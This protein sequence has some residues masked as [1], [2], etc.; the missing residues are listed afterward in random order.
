MPGDTDTAPAT[1]TYSPEER[2]YFSSGEMTREEARELA[3]IPWEQLKERLKNDYLIPGLRN[4]FSNGD[5]N[6]TAEFTAEEFRQA[7]INQTTLKRKDYPAFGSGTWTDIT[8]W[9][10]AVERINAAGNEVINENYLDFYHAIGDT[11][12][13]PYQQLQT[14]IQESQI[15]KQPKTGADPVHLFNGNFVFATTDL[16]IDGAGMNF[17]F[18]RTYSQLD[19]YNGPLGFNWDHSYNL[20]LRVSADMQMITASTGILR[21]NAYRKHYIYDYWTPSD[22]VDTILLQKGNTFLLRNPDGSHVLYQQHPTQGP[23]IHIVNRIEDRFGNYLQFFYEDGKLNKIAVNHV[24]RLVH[25]FYDTFDR[26]IAIK[27]FTQRLWKYIYDDMGDLLAVTTPGTVKYKKGLTTFY[28][29]SSSSFS[30]PNAQH[31]LISIIDADGHIYLENEYGIEKNL[32]SYN[33]VIRQRLGN[34]DTLFDY[35]DV[36][37]N[38]EYPYQ[39]NEQPTCQTIVTERDGMQARYLFNRYGNMIFKEEYARLNG[40]PKLISSHYRY[41][42]EGNLIGVIS[43]MGFI[44]QYLY[45][46]DYFEKRFPQDNDYRC[47]NDSNLTQQIRQGFNTLLSVVKRK[48]YIN[49]NMSGG[50]WSEDIFPD[51]YYANHEDIIQK[52][53]YENKFFQLITSSDPRFT[54]SANPNIVEPEIYHVHLTKYNYAPGNGFDFFYLRSL[55]L[56]GSTLPDGTIAEPL[57]T[58]FEEYDTK[59]RLIK[60]VASNGLIKI[61]NYYGEEDGLLNGFLKSTEIDPAGIAIKTG[62]ERD[63]LGRVTKIYKPKYY[64]FL[65]DRFFSTSHYD[66]LN[67]VVKSISSAPLSVQTFNKYNR[68]GNLISSKT[69][70]KDRGNMLTGIFEVNSKYD[71][72]FHLISQDTGNKETGQTKRNKNIHDRAGR[73][74]ISI[75]ASGFKTKLLYNERGLQW[76]TITDYG[77]VHAVTKN[78]FDADGR[79]IRTVDPRGNISRFTYDTLG[80]PVDTEDAKGNKSIRHYDKIGNIT[81]E[82]FFEKE[83]DIRY[84]LLSR[85]EYKHDEIGRVIKAGINKFDE[86]LVVNVNYLK[87][88]FITEGPGEL[89]VNYFF[90]N[91]TGK[92]YKTIDQSGKI[93]TSDFDLLGRIIKKTDP[94]GNELTYQYDKE[95]NIIRTDRKEVT[96]NK[97]TNEIINARYFAETAIYDEKNRII[98]KKNSLG[99]KIKY[100]YDSRNNLVQLIDPLDNITQNQYDLFSR[101][102]HNIR[103]LHKYL[104]GE[105]PEEVKTSYTYNHFDLIT[106]QKDAL[107]R[108]TEFIYNSSGRQISSILPDG[109]ADMITYDRLGNITLYKDR[110]GL[111][112]IFKYDELNRNIELAIDT[113]TLTEGVEIYGAMKFKTEYDGMSRIVKIENDH[114]ITEYSFNSLGFNLEE[115]NS[116]KPIAGMS[117][118]SALS[119][120]REFNVSGSQISLTYPSGRRIEYDRDILER[121]IGFRQTQKGNDYPGD[122]LTPENYT[123]AEIEYEGLQRK[124]IRKSNNS[125]TEFNYDFGARLIEIKH[126][127][128]NMFF[129]RLQFIFDA[130]NNMRQQVEFSNEFQ[131]THS[132]SYDSFSRILTTKGDDNAIVEELSVLAPS[133]LQIPAT[134]PGYQMQINDMLLGR[135]LPENRNYGYDKV[136]NRINYQPN[137]LDQYE[138]VNGNSCL[139]NKMGNLTEDNEFVYHYN[140]LNQ[141]SKVK[142]KTDESE[143]NFLY[144][145]LGRRCAEIKNG[146]L[147]TMIYDGHN[148]LEEY[149]NGLLR[150]SI[151]SDIGQDNIISSAKEN[152]DFYFYA[153]L[154]KSV[155]FLF[156]GSE[157]FNF[158][159]YDEFGNI[160]NSRNI[161]DGNQFRFGGKRLLTELKKYDFIYRTY[162]PVTGRF[163][164][165]DPKGFVDG[166]NLYCYVGNNPKTFID[167]LGTEREA[168]LLNISPGDTTDILGGATEIID[169]ILQSHQSRLEKVVDTAREMVNTLGFGEK[170]EEARLLEYIRKTW[171]EALKAGKYKRL[172][173]L[174]GKGLDVLG[175]GFQ[176]YEK[177]FGGES[178]A[179]TMEFKIFDGLISG[180]GNIS[181]GMKHPLVTAIDAILGIAQ[182]KAFGGK[183]VSMGDSMNVGYSNITGVF[184]AIFTGD[185]S[186]LEK[187]RADANKPISEGGMSLIPRG[188]WKIGEAYKSSDL[189]FFDSVTQRVDRTGDFYGGPDSTAGRAGAFAASIPI[190]GELGEGIGHGLAWTVTELN[191]CRFWCD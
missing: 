133:H 139:Y 146:E 27:D 1:T 153:D 107:G 2:V 161:N 173:G 78:Y 138:N 145:S 56:P 18:S 99:N 17:S 4:A 10:N 36:V 134:I 19:H 184:E 149:E 9:N 65:D 42:R 92:V 85:R 126:A 171:P 174:A 156:S 20:W 84:K 105:T 94:N 151:L 189:P 158:Y 141:L 132:Y 57:I 69:E 131:K 34:G 58:N 175:G 168:R 3:T 26:I 148:L 159:Q 115:I 108:E 63:I 13:Q 103:Y 60:T 114:V 113:S 81:L 123:V 152:T 96:R 140:H 25:F 116:Y 147:S 180:G 23:F 157:K 182:E 51:I 74:Y 163:I 160:E 124:R 7:V 167:S 177:A 44:T 82:L 143:T 155:R 120:K 50:L 111:Q 154:T 77:G 22:G 35:A 130:L 11:Q 6:L 164:Q 127:S 93:I 129:L 12:F 48:G 16:E 21:T 142:R 185:T 91:K 71:D 83:S 30:D 79:V 128:N 72:E 100:S 181:I 86:S 8:E 178:P 137:L 169:D 59:G 188:F 176:F 62:T 41:N 39:S 32:L 37:E 33:R 43:P 46:R 110:N 24:D 54:K 38:F 183:Y 121:V 191:K 179:K 119:I 104:P 31:N 165:R 117:F 136:G 97:L 66:E 90:Y 187:L 14:F 101:V 150:L 29:Y 122:A 45:G 28:E 186:G 49:L 53:T 135:T 144:D 87:S 95:N 47:Y 125:S 112:K 67:Q 75:A 76:Q 166:T 89:L 106:H 70:L 64:E 73:P 190:L 55:E 88:S 15:S 68:T 172:F 40:I 61:N 5:R 118:L 80:R 162:D 102:T 109:S 98:E 170:K 52:F